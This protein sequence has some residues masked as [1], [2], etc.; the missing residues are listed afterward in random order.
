M[1]GHRSFLATASLALAGLLTLRGA[2]LSPSPSTL[3]VPGRA[4]ANVSL[5]SQDAFVAAAWSAALPDGTTDIFGATSVDG[6]RVFTAPVRVNRTP[7][8]ARVNGEQ[9]PRA[10]LVRRADG[11]PLLSIVWTSKGKDGTAIVTARSDDGGRTFGETTLVPGGEAAGNRG[12]EN[13]S[14]DAQGRVRVLWLDH[15]E[16]AMAMPPAGAEHHHGH[17]AS[18]D[19]KKDS[20]DAAQASKLY[21]ATIGDASSPRLLLGGV[22]YCCK[23]AIVSG[24]D[25]TLYAAWRHVFPG[26][27]RDIAFM[28]SRDGG[29]TFGRPIRVSEDQWHLEGCPDDGP[30]MA[31]DGG[32]TVH[33]VWPTL[34][35]DGPQ[36]QP[37]IGIFY[38]TSADGGAFSPRAR[39]PTEGLPHHPQIIVS[40]GTIYLAWD[41]L[42]NGTRQAVVARRAVKETAA[43]FTRT[44]LGTDAPGIYPSIAAVRAG[45]L[46]AWSSG[47]EDAVIRI[48]TVR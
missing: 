9:P 18:A 21:I 30:A 25:G 37:S 26:N 42:K 29:R 41:E 3:A 40:G 33:L 14:V 35:T 48:T 11:P 17:D 24:G 27:L 4:N 38:A 47:K 22:C 6:G 13:V 23:T 15:R 19:A 10:A 32:N 2:A 7:G 28:A 45:A 5:A 16:M 20:A 34:V 46:A 39:V 43:P 44:V 1:S 12:W 36:G 31:V 8:D